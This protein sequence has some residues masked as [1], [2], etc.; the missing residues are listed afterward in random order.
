MFKFSFLLALLGGIALSSSLR[1]E[2]TPA[3][4]T[5]EVTLKIMGMT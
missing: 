1:A 3:T 5:K 4:A 2:E